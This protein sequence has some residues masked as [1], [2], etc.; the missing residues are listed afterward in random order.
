MSAKVGL[1]EGD[2][3]IDQLD[4]GQH[5]NVI[6]AG[7]FDGGY[8]LEPSAT[9]IEQIGEQRQARGSKAAL[10]RPGRRRSNTSRLIPRRPE[11]ISPRIR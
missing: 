1:K 7:T 9:I 8:T 3:T 5:L 2:Y 4:M 6:K 11:N 10:Q